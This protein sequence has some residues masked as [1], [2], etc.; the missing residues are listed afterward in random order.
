MGIGASLQHH[1]NCENNWISLLWPL[2]VME[3]LTSSKSRTPGPE[4]FHGFLVPCSCIS[5]VIFGFEVSGCTYFTFRPI[6][7]TS[8]G[9]GN[10]GN[11]EYFVISCIFK[12]GLSL[13]FL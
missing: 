6:N 2:M 13:L 10:Q 12:P 3:F 1:W 9:I 8:H 11:Q 7:S 5:F 4:P